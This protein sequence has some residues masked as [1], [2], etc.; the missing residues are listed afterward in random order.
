MRLYYTPISPYARK[1]IMLASLLKQDLE[2]VLVSPLTDDTVR[3]ANP[4]GKVPALSDGDLTLLDSTLICEYLDDKNGDGGS[5][6]YLCRNTP[7][8]YVVQNAQALADGILDAAV[9]TV[10]EL[11]RD[12]AEQS[13]YWLDRWQRAIVHALASIKVAAIG[14]SEQVHIGTISTICALGYL[15]FRLPTLNWR[16]HNRPLAQWYEAMQAQAWVQA[17]A[18]KA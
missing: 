5:T 1:V 17:S 2:L 11:R 8:Y 14:S 3:E 10:M 9:S 6:S 7:Q 13:R 18:P 12:D 15:D 16:E 4:L